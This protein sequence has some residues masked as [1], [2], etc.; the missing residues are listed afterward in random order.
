M[1]ALNVSARSKKAEAEYGK[2]AVDVVPNLAP[3]ALQA[4]CDQFREKEVNCSSEKIADVEK[5]TRQQSSCALWTAEK[6]SRRTASVFRDVVVW[7]PSTP[8]TP[9]VQRLVYGTFTEN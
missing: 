4:V 7:K 5:L 8:V 1:S 2:E 6:R 9:L 3:V